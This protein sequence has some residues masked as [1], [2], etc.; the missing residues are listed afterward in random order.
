[1]STASRLPFLDLLRA[2]ASQAIVCHHLAFYGPLSDS[3]HE[4]ATRLI[5]W[6]ADYGRLAVQIFF[7]MSGYLTAKGLARNETP[8]LR[9]AGTHLLG[10]Y[11]RIAFPYLG[12]LVVAIIANELARPWLN[13][14]SIVSD[15]P[16]PGQLLAHVFLV[17]DLIGYQ[18]LSAG[19]WYLA[20]DL[21]LV[22]FV[23]LVFWSS[24][25]A[26]GKEK[27][28]RV[29]RA[30]LGG[31]GVASLFWFNRN[32]SLDH[33][34]L[35]FLGSYVLGLLVCWQQ[36]GSV[37]KWAFWVYSTLV[38]AAVA[39]D[40]R[41]RLLVAA[42]TAVALVLAQRYGWLGRWP[43]SRAVDKL[44]SVSYSLFL[45][46]FPV[47][48]VVTAWW[49]RNL[50][51]DPWWSLFGM[52]VAYVAS[53]IAAFVFCGFERWAVALPRTAQRQMSSTTGL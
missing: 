7:V 20:I 10:R 39:I 47:C 9:D 51:V 16:T 33:Y 35:Y 52:G 41:S 27:G 3:A 43:R 28:P 31:L 19:I 17:H 1:M 40:F 26:V 32:P 50:P 4:V 25:R 53:M 36:A 22:T 11:R 37:P 6:L 45:I 13:D 23:T 49:Y 21:Q 14:P 29:A 34:A 46:H 38:V 5:D 8:G 44:G 48:L 18:P 30:L 12:A 42:A 24:G 15:R 2:L